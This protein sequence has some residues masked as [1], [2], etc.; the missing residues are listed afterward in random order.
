M[1]TSN[2]TSA[3]GEYRTRPRTKTEST[4]SKTRDIWI[5]RSNSC[6]DWARAREAASTAAGSRAKNPADCAARSAAFAGQESGRKRSNL[7][8]SGRPIQVGGTIHVISKESARLSRPRRRQ[9]HLSRCCFVAAKRQGISHFSRPWR[10]LGT[11]VIYVFLCVLVRKWR[12]S[13]RA[14][15]ERRG[16]GRHRFLGHSGHRRIGR[17]TDLTQPLLDAKIK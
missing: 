17:P 4:A 13:I 8:R 2:I 1:V 6:R 5:A 16:R 12:S 14:F 11:A 3:H 15:R 10:D 9:I 7:A